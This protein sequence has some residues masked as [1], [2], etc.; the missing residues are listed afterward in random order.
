MMYGSAPMI[1]ERGEC[2][3]DTIGIAEPLHPGTAKK[4]VQSAAL[5]GD[6]VEAR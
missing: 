6:Q 5:K 4:G 3:L 1:Y 2:C